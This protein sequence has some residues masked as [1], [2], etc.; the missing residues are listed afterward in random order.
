MLKA[1]E[2]EPFSLMC[3]CENH[4]VVGPGFQPETVSISSS[5]GAMAGEPRSCGWEA[6]SGRP[7]AK[8]GKD[9]DLVVS[10]HTLSKRAGTEPN[11]VY[12][13]WLLSRPGF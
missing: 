11:R 6:G 8:I 9:I 5:S 2:M 12:A 10:E 13:F 1:P 3:R 7:N 4:Y